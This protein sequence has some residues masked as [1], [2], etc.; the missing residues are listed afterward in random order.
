MVDG[1]FF[2]TGPIRAFK[3]SDLISNHTMGGFAVG[4]SILR[5]EY[6]KVE[7]L[8]QRHSESV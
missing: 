8:T 6:E 3:I 5:N 4:D 2:P 1:V 7:Q